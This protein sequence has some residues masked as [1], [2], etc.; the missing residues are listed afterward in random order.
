MT[1]APFSF[2]RRYAEALLGRLPVGGRWIE[3]AY[4]RERWEGEGRPPF[5]KWR[6]KTDGESTPWM[7]WYDFERLRTRLHPAKFDIV[8]HFNFHRDDFNWFDLIRRNE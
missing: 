5:H 4:P 6:R 1:N 2:A 3:L 8:L 7:E